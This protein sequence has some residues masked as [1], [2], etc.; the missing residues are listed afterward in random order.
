MIVYY[1]YR[2]MLK[3]L[4]LALYPGPYY[5]PDECIDDQVE[6]KYFDNSKVC[7]NTVRIVRGRDL[8]IASLNIESEINVLYWAC[9]HY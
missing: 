2:N 5:G 6:N 1:V 9:P 8:Q 4:Y 3:E 7:M